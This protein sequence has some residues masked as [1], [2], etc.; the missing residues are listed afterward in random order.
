MTTAPRNIAVLSR[1]THEAI[2][3]QLRACQTTDEILAFE[4]WFNSTAKDLKLYSII[5]ELL[6][7]RSISR[8]TASKW[9][10]ALI[11]DRDTKLRNQV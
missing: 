2:I 10:E 4:T 3:D 11:Q 1:G 9:F 6:R 7:N 5:S 8:A